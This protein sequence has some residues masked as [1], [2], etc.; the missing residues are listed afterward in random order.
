MKIAR[1]FPNFQTNL[2]YTEHY[3]AKE[4]SE[5]G[6]KTTFVTSDKYLDHIKKYIEQ[7]DSA[8][9]YTYKYFDLYRL[10]SILLV[11]KSIIIEVR[12]LYRLLFK[13]N[14]EVFHFLGIATFTT[15]T[16]LW[17]HFLSRNKTPIVI[18]DHSDSRTHVREGKIAELFYFF[19]RINVGLL[20]KR[21]YKYITFSE[22][23]AELLSKRFK[24]AKNKFQ[25]IKLGYDQDNYRYAPKHKNNS[26]K[27]IIGYAGKISESKRIDFLIRTI[28]NLSIKDRI[29]LIIVGYNDNNPYC[30]S[31]KELA[32]NRHFEIEFR[33]FATSV[34]LS[35]FYNYID[36]A[37]YPGGISITTIE[38]SGCGTP[39]IIY[40]SI[41]GLEERISHDR[42]VLFDTEEELKDYI[43]KYFC[44]SKENKIDN[45]Y[46][47]KKTKEQFS[48][49]KISKDYLKLYKQAIN[50]K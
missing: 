40:K 31:L 26:S 47:A 11:D 10:K 27:L 33:P 7:E 34:E 42:G 1:L 8:G 43:V 20:S 32:E 37:I 14:F 13:S 18:S 44:L 46:I 25:I 9:Y 5:N 29:K 6:H 23:S 41:E 49:K 2:K 22:A 4:L 50:E 19:F 30:L 45:S 16:A 21:I 3:L 15:F 12:K 48:W 28:D 24:I 17:L 39:V 36:L 35:E 38:A